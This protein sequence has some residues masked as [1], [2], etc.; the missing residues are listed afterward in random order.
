MINK[1]DERHDVII[2]G[3]GPAGLGIAIVLE[4]LGLNYLILEKNKIGSSFRK[5]PKETRFISPSFTGNFFMMP[6]LNAI[7]PETSPAFEL[8]TEHPTGNEY[9]DHLENVASFYELAIE[10]NI[11]VENIEKK[12]NSFLVQTN[13]KSFKSKF[14]NWVAGEYQVPKTNAF[15]VDLSQILKEKIP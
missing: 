14:V 4:Q 8:L 13:T 7:S 3:A 6:D 1:I 9:A 11:T 2:V 5:W 15:E 10:T 12:D